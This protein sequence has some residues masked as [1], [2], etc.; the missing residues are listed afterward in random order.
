VGGWYPETE[1]AVAD[2]GCGRTANVGNEER[3]KKK[4]IQAG[5]AGYSKFSRLRPK[6]TN[7]FTNWSIK[8]ASPL[9]RTAITNALR[10]RR[11]GGRRVTLMRLSPRK[12]RTR[13]AKLPTPVSGS[14]LA[15]HP[16][17]E[18][19]SNEFKAPTVVNEPTLGGAQEA[20]VTQILR[21]RL[22]KP[23][24]ARSSSF[25]E[26]ETSKSDPPD[27]IG[28]DCLEPAEPSDRIAAVR[29]ALG[30]AHRG[31]AAVVDKVAE[32]QQAVVNRCALQYAWLNEEHKALL[33]RAQTMMAQ[34]QRSGA[35]EER[36]RSIL[37]HIHSVIE[38]RGARSIAQLT[39]L[40]QIANC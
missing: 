36:I 27:Q 31:G 12:Q 13:A 23:N 17:S 26:Q 35:P 16:A 7:D 19:V 32:V 10:A 39:Q 24:R 9:H 40:T 30:L 20:N 4:R 29:A 5:Y 1:G 11:Q 8:M 38:S 15:L 2:A 33:L 3:R 6:R 14:I 22:S 28:K 18:D 25:E 37:Q 34:L 21:N